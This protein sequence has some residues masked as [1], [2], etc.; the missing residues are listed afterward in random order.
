MFDPAESHGCCWLTCSNL[1]KRC[2]PGAA[3]QQMMQAVLLSKTA[4]PGYRR[5]WFTIMLETAVMVC[6]HSRCW[7]VGHIHPT[8]QACQR[9][10]SFKQQQKPGECCWP[11]CTASL[12]QGNTLG[13]WVLL[14][15]YM[16]ESARKCC[17][18][19]Q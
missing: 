19:L 15:P 12:R 16:Q 9:C 3:D 1:K 11:G 6:H 14:Q 5:S 18:I 8:R 10:A 17:R 2:A 7:Y 13:V 4:R